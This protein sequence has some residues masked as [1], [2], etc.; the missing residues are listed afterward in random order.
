MDGRDGGGI[1]GGRTDGEGL[2]VEEAEEAER[3]TAPPQ[4]AVEENQAGPSAGL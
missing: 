2:G 3:E 1:L 4:A